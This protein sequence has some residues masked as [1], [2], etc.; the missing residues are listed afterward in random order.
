MS[1]RNPT[2]VPPEDGA[3]ET[4]WQTLLSVAARVLVKSADSEAFLDWIAE[5]GPAL[6]PTVVAHIAPETGPPALFFRSIGVAI[7]NA[8]PFPDAGFRPRPL[9][10]PGRNE[11]CSCGSGRKY[12]HCCLPLKAAMPDLRQ[13][14]LLRHVLDHTA[15][16][17]FSTLPGSGVDLMHVYDTAEQWTEEGDAGRAAALLE[18]WFAADRKLE[19]RLEPLFDALMNAYLA[20][21]SER[22]RTRLIAEVRSRGDSTLRAAALQRHA[23]MLAD[24]GK[25]EEAW[26]AFCE[27]QREDPDNPM[28]AAL[29]ISLLVSR[30]EAEQA[31]ERARFWATRLERMRDPELADLIEFLRL[32][33]VDPSSALSHMSRAQYPDLDRLARLLEGAPSVEVHYAIE[34]PEEEGILRP[35]AELAAL[36]QR[37][38]RVFEQVKP[39]LTDTQHGNEGV[40]GEAEAWLAFLERERLAWQSF[41]VLDDLVMA[42]DALPAMN[43][44]SVV[45]PLLGRAAAILKGVV[46][47]C[48]HA[49]PT[50]DWAW[51]ENRPAL[52]LLAHRAFH[53]RDSRDAAARGV[54]VDSAERLIA[55]NPRD[56]HG[57]RDD[58]TR[59]YI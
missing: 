7:Y 1:P 14:N 23:T 19:G 48:G 4:E 18:P 6:V 57:L 42:G 36:E 5:A 29:E 11:T 30:G 50:L 9:R 27:A 22:K 45:L 35:D 47:A 16:R 28:L 3:A 12:K 44:E 38:R 49:H 15:K 2:D 52:R 34:H 43:A 31:R 56:N 13:F 54:F 55:L 58:L 8:M 37:W 40:W 39:D 25:T 26:R 53:A 59:A 21:G 24:R 20:L 17:D 33:V 32:V 10:E 51:R 46:D 41:D